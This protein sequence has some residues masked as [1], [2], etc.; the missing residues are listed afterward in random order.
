MGITKDVL[1][2]NI[3]ILFIYFAVITL[4]SALYSMVGDDQI[5]LIIVYMLI[6]IGHFLV[7]FVKTIMYLFKGQR[8]KGLAYFLSLL[9]IL[10][11]GFP[12]CYGSLALSG[13]VYKMFH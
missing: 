4:I 11:I 13:V 12:T 10:L 8:E 2:I 6:L 7:N 9:L 5:Q 3:R 1:S